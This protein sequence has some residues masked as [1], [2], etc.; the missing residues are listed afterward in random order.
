[1]RID[2][3]LDKSDLP[4]PLQ[5]YWGHQFSSGT[6]P[7]P[8]YIAFQAAYGRWLKKLLPEYEVDMHK[9][10]YEFSCVICKKGTGGAPDKYVYLSISDVRFFHG[11]WIYNILIR[12][13]KHAKDWTGG[14]NGFCQ[15]D[16]IK[17]R[18]DELMKRDAA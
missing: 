16:Q 1:M 11:E 9:N 4:R 18:V 5:K 3:F 14:T 17:E 10:H 7:G 15:I 8:D 6:R 13:M 2:H 12:T